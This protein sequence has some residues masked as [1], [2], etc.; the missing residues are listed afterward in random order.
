[1]ASPEDRIQAVSA[2]GQAY[3]RP[4]SPHGLILAK[5]QALTILKP[6]LAALDRIAT[7]LEQL[8]PALTQ[9][10]REAHMS[11]HLRWT[12]PLGPSK[13]DD[14]GSVRFHGSFDA[15]DESIDSDQVWFVA[16]FAY[17]G[18]TDPKIA[19]RMGDRDQVIS[20]ALEDL[21]YN[22]HLLMWPIPDDAEWV[23]NEE[24]TRTE[25]YKDPIPPS[26][27][28]FLDHENCSYCDAAKRGT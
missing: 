3:P 15:S 7:A 12:G 19:L 8:A 1:M 22:P 25:S 26:T 23:W 24:N 17:K 16:A 10:T 27:S 6:L 2:R 21:P 18:Q 5:E 13:E 20:K 11:G 28:E 14:V 4:T 9:A